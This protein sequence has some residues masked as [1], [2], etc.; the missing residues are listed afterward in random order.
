MNPSVKYDQSSSVTIRSESGFRYLYKIG[1]KGL[2]FRV[3]R[4]RFKGSEVPT[5]AFQTSE[6]RL[7]STFKAILD[8][9]NF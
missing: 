4:H 8:H 6:G 3:Q 7:G 9:P 5:F 1:F 2:T